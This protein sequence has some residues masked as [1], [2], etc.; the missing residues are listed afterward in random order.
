MKPT[1]SYQDLM[2]TEHSLQPSTIA[3][4]EIVSVVVSCLIAEWVVLA[5]IGTNKLALAVPIA[6][7]LALIPGNAE[8]MAW[9][10]G[11]ERN[12][13]VSVGVVLVIFAQIPETIVER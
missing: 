8:I 10:L 3:L 2:Q 7:A 1:A 12:F 11:Q 6:L 4:W 13:D 9:R 5:F